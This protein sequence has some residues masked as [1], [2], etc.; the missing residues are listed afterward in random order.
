MAL[1]L[2]IKDTGSKD[3]LQFDIDNVKM[4]LVNALRR[5]MISEV[6]TVAFET[7]DFES[8]SIKITEN[9]SQFHNEFLLHRIGLIPI[10]IPDTDNFNESDY[11]FSLDIENKTNNVL[12][13]TAGDIKVMNNLTGVEEPTDKFFP[14]DPISNENIMIV[15]L[16]PNPAGNSE[17]LSFTG[18]A[19]VGNGGDDARY[20]PTSVCFYTNTIDQDAMNEAYTKYREGNEGEDSEKLKK[21]FAINESERHFARDSEGEPNKFSFTVESIGMIP[22]EQI[23]GRAIDILN[24][25]LEKLQTELTKKDS[26]YLEIEETPTAMEAFDI[27]IDN[28]S[29]TLG[30]V[31]QEHANQLISNSDLVYVGYMNPHPLKKNIKLR[32]ALTQNNRDNVINQ[33]TFVCQNIANQCNS[34][35]SLVEQKFGSIGMKANAGPRDQD[36]TVKQKKKIRIKKEPVAEGRETTEAEAGINEEREPATNTNMTGGE[37]VEMTDNDSDLE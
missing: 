37:Y 10:N 6:N 22:P 31:I 5:I 9:T 28:E 19:R 29:H 27:T 3:I 14:K 33:V 13:V 24:G 11:T 16:L 18:T 25:K 26:E 21:R 20:S 36:A 23:L 2:N 1:N 7:S 35:K 17:R 4:S 15:R 12:Y 8:S 32:V 34:I 30:F